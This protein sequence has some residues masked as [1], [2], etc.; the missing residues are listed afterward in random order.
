M[1]ERSD[2]PI[3][4]DHDREFVEALQ[5]SGERIDP[6][7]R[8]RLHETRFEIALGNRSKIFW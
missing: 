3:K 5:E 2:I 4:V 6:A 1:P 7:A 8:E